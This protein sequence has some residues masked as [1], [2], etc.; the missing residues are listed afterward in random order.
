VERCGKYPSL[1]GAS[2]TLTITCSGIVE[3]QIFNYRISSMTF[4]LGVFVHRWI[5]C[6]QCSLSGYLEP[7]CCKETTAV[8]F[9]YQNDHFHIEW[10]LQSPGATRN[11][12]EA[13]YKWKLSDRWYCKILG[14]FSQV[15]RV[16]W[17]EELQCVT[18]RDILNLASV[19]GCCDKQWRNFLNLC[20]LDSSTRVHSAKATTSFS[21][22]FTLWTLYSMYISI[23]RGNCKAVVYFEATC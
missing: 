11:F 4:A 15:G 8:D 14:A 7:G 12:W 6:I 21:L 3:V 9:T 19:I 18:K 23:P 10:L 13:R 5:Y 16:E 22:K 1:T 2:T 17:K 20:F